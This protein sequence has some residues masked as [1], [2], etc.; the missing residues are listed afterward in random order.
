MMAK[1]PFP[2][3]SASRKSAQGIRASGDASLA[4]LRTGPFSMHQAGPYLA[5]PKGKGVFHEAEFGLKWV[6]PA[7]S[8]TLTWNPSGCE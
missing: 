3:T 2:K 6:L 1:E 8:S 5:C 4:R 7:P